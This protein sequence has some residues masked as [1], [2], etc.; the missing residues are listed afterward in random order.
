PSAP[1]S[2]QTIEA[3][4]PT[5]ADREEAQEAAMAGLRARTEA[6][7]T[8]TD[9]RVAAATAPAAAPAPAK[10]SPPAAAT[11]APA[12][13]VPPPLAPSAGPPPGN[14]GEPPKRGVWWRFLAASVV[15]I[16]AAATAT[17]VSGLVAGYDL[18]AGL[19]GIRGVQHL[20]QGTSPSG[21]Q[22]VLVLG[23]DKRP[24]ETDHGRSDTTIL[25]R[26][27]S[28]GIRMLSIPR[29][30]KIDNIPNHGGPWKMNA[31]Y[32]FGG[33]QLTTEVVKQLTGLQIN[34]VLNIDFTG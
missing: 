30:L 6:H 3:D 22:T 5:L 20:L 28:S 4:T 27:T 17:A 9:Q 29:D 18:A 32:T 15:I 25:L 21:P 24:G 13:K 19:G 8:K 33:P 34:H 11:P 23:S 10:P 26:V 2:D 14:A 31:A 16:V 12:A 1:A 7:A